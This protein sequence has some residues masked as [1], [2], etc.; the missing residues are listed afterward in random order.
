MS[1]Y[2]K[3]QEQLIALRLRRE[4]LNN[5]HNHIIALH[6][7]DA[8]KLAHDLHVKLEKQLEPN[9][10]EQLELNIKITHITQAIDTIINTQPHLLLD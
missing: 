8:D 9:Y 2:N 3:L 5:E 6:R 7:I 4:T 10:A 1:T